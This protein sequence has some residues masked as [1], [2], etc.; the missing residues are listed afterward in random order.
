MLRGLS[1]ILL[2]S[3]AFAR[4][5]LVVADKS[6]TG[7]PVTL[8]GSLSF[9]PTKVTLAV[10]G[11]NHSEKEIVAFVAEVSAEPFFANREELDRYYAHSEI[12]P[13]GEFMLGGGGPVDY[14]IPEETING[15][16]Y[17]SVDHIEGVDAKI[18][19]IQ[20]GEGTT[21]GDDK[22]GEAVRSQRPELLAALTHLLQVHISEGDDEFVKA[23]Y[24]LPITR[25]TLT[26]AIVH[27][28]QH[29]QKTKGTIAV[30]TRIQERLAS[31]NSRPFNP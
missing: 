13:G 26:S 22:A 23:L 28:Y 24:S 19:W 15:Q 20:F 3:V 5:P 12:S 6:P 21:W 10:K 2:S 31:G 25:G 27:G 11:V 1:L 4:D 16:P 30:I 14:P 18:L 7:T 17:S 8:S 29:L 9:A